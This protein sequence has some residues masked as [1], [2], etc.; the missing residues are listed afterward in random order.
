MTSDIACGL[1]N[2]SS[3]RGGGG[4]QADGEWVEALSILVTCGAEEV[5]M[6]HLLAIA[7][8]VHTNTPPCS[9]A[10]R[11]SFPTKAEETENADRRRLGKERGDREPLFCLPNLSN[12]CCSTL[13][14]TPL[15]KLRH[16]KLSSCTTPHHTTPPLAVASK[17]AFAW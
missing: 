2:N 11:V 15:F 7:S 16:Q 10:H 13:A 6:L 17:K 8:L 5:C 9:A 12:S 4:T 1:G 14:R 3:N